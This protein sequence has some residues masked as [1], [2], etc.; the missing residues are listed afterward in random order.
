MPARVMQGHALP[1][2]VQRSGWIRID[3]A[4]EPRE[5][6]DEGR[7]GELEEALEES[8]IP[9][10]VEVVNLQH[11]DDGYRA[12]VASEGIAWTA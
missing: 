12:R 8:S 7:I 1:R 6:F 10:R 9:Y 2:S 11:A 4:I 3:L 5:G